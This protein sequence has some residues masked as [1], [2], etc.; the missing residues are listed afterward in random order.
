MNRKLIISIFTFLALFSNTVL[1]D[2]S[3]ILFFMLPVIAIIAF[4]F[5]FLDNTFIAYVAIKFICKRQIKD[6]SHFFTFML[7]HTFIVGISEAVFLMLLLTKFFTSFTFLS[8]ETGQFLFGLFYSILSGITIFFVFRY[9]LP[10]ELGMKEKDIKIS[11]L[12]MSILTN[13]GVLL[14]CFYILSYTIIIP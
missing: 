7:K 1:A 9:F 14:L 3:G 5:A 6:R 10:K 11:S 12:L 2:M 4:I 13:P 8:F